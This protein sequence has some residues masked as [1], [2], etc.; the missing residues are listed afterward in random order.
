M[1]IEGIVMWQSSDKL[2]ELRI[3]IC[4]GKVEMS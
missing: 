1:A 2:A 4:Q 3:Q